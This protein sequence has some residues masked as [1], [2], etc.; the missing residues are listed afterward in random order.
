V[1]IALTTGFYREVVDIILGRLGWL[2]PNSPF[3]KG[4][5]ILDWSMAGDEVA[6]G[7]P[8]PDM[9]FECMKNLNIQSPLDVINIGDTPSDLESGKRAGVRF[10]FGLTNGTH[11]REQLDSIPN[12]G[13]FRS[14]KEFQEFLEFER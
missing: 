1:K 4:N 12:D 7:R 14:L 5:F 13:L 2:Y 8:A 3:T 11:T 9:I 6:Q 10:S